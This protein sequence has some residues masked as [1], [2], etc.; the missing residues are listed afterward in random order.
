[1]FTLFL[2]NQN[3]SYFCQSCSILCY[4]WG[5]CGNSKRT[6]Q[7]GKVLLQRFR[8]LSAL[9]LCVAVMASSGGN[10]MMVHAS[11]DTNTNTDVTDE[12]KTSNYD[13]VMDQ[14]RGIGDL[15]TH[16]VSNGVQWVDA[17]VMGLIDKDTP[18]N[19]KD[20]FYLSVNKDWILQ[21][22]D[23]ENVDPDE[24][25]D[26]RALT[27][28]TDV[29][30]KNIDEMF[31]NLLN[32][33]FIDT[34]NVNM[35]PEELQYVQEELKI[36]LDALYDE[37]NRNAN[38]L[39]TLKSYLDK[40]DDIETMEELTRYL[41]DVSGD[42]L[43]GVP[44][45]G[46]G[47]ETIYTDQN[48]YHAVIYPIM[49]ATF[50]LGSG[51]NYRDMSVS[52]LRQ[53]EATRDAM[54]YFLTKFGYT[55]K[56]IK[57]ELKNMYRFESRL[58]DSM[59][60]KIDQLVL[61]NKDVMTDYY[62]K[63]ND[64]Y[65]MDTLKSMAGEFPI[66]EL[67]SAYGYGEVDDFIVRDPDF[68]KKLGKI[69][70]DK[71]INEWKSFYKMQT[72]IYM[73]NYVDEET[74]AIVSAY[75]QG[76]DPFAK[77]NP[78]Y[79]RY[80]KTKE[81]QKI[82]DRKE[83]A[84]SLLTEDVNMLYFA[85]FCSEE[86]KQK[87]LEMTKLIQENLC[88]MFETTTWLSEESKA[89]VIEKARNMEL[90]V[91]YPDVFPSDRTLK[92]SADENLFEMAR[93]INL[94]KERLAS[95]LVGK[96]DDRSDWNLND[97]QL[98]SLETNAYHL[99]QRNYMMILAG[100]TNDFTFDIDAEPEVNLARLGTIIGHE[101]THG[102]DSEGHMY[103][104]DGWY[105]KFLN[106]DEALINDNDILAHDMKLNHLRLW[107][108]A[109]TPLPDGVLYESD[110]SA[111][112]IADMGGVKACLLAAEDMEDFD[113]D[114][115]FRSYAELWRMA[116]TMEHEKD[117]RDSDPH[118]CQY[119]RVNVTLSQFDKFHE[120]YGITE[121]DGMYTEEKDRILVW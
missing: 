73:S 98:S 48:K 3:L 58:V 2:F 12:K 105:E 56:D 57:K 117:I 55:K 115:F 10:V 23:E 38:G 95:Q 60:N 109:I 11:A 36:L 31:N 52:G 51:N 44:V 22:I 30:D 120:I 53:K 71:Y 45:L 85:Y 78:K 119:L 92:L 104:K 97:A 91:L 93:D 17:S 63:Y 42:N 27:S 69:Y 106:K 112:A 99:H 72:A 90:R 43:V 9:M 20:D 75:M 29:V 1:M 86:E 62:K 5:F 77:T 37:E 110:V 59:D 84:M 34:N 32:N 114:L 76:T 107:Y 16:N 50:N 24:I 18:T 39:S 111:E 87:I 33:V 26:K 101:M 79:K 80:E 74:A 88:E 65:S 46:L 67:L 64:S 14:F 15:I 121:G 82:A 47:A 108:G 61:G 19:P 49:P 118:P 81:E 94:H 21:T 89:N 35:D 83:L 103:N 100:I 66:E 4:Y 25:F 28:G 41:T 40:I 96:E 6:K 116:D 13:E 54:M 70:S 113:Y 102:F 8:R 68:I 7:G